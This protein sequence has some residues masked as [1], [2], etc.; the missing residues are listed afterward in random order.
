MSTAKEILEAALKLDPI[1][2]ARVAE[3]ILRSL[4]EAEIEAIEDG[5][6]VREARAALDEMRR[7]GEK[8]IPLE[9]VKRE[10]GLP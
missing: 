4:S 1:E 7:T 10:L 8:P 6:D 5:E 2:R 3:S 9:Q